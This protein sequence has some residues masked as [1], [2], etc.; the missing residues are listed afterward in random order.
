MNIVEIYGAHPYSRLWHLIQNPR[1][2]GRGGKGVFQT[3]SSRCNSA[4]RIECPSSRPVP[5]SFQI[6]HVKSGLFCLIWLFKHFSM[7][8]YNLAQ[9]F[10]FI[11]SCKKCSHL[12]WESLFL[13]ATNPR[14]SGTDYV[15]IAFL[16]FRFSFC[17]FFSRII[18][19]HRPRCSLLPAM[20]SV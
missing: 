12:V 2:S 16:V 15:L 17:L 8:G 7:T 6:P 13:L 11:H 3:P 10:K 9:E 19:F 20:Y 5:A 4:T 18:T 1:E 14:P